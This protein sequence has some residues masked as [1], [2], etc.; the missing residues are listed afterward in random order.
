[1]KQKCSFNLIIFFGAMIL[2]QANGS[3]IQYQG[4][5]LRFVLLFH[6]APFAQV[7]PNIPINMFLQFTENS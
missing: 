4:H 5:G 2:F 7:S 1:M 6:P 3:Q